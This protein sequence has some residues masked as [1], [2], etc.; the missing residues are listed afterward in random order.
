MCKFVEVAPYQE[1]KD[2]SH[3]EYVFQ[4]I[5]D[6]GGEGIILRDPNTP[7]VAGRSG[8]YLKHKVLLY[9][10]PQNTLH[11]SNSN[12]QEI[13]GRRGQNNTKNEHLI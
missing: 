8:G 9:P 11:G 12:L 4:E 13:Q 10:P 3:L 7:Y 5:I 2:T 6:K 1:C